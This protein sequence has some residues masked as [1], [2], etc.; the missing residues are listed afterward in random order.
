MRRRTCGA[1]LAAALFCC[2]GIAR[3]EGVV[4]DF[5]RGVKGFGD[6]MKGLRPEKT[7]KA[8]SDISKIVNAGDK[9]WRIIERNERIPGSDLRFAAAVPEGVSGWEELSRWG[10]PELCRYR[11]EVKDWLGRRAVDVEYGVLRTPGGSL[12]GQGRFLTGVSIVPLHVETRKDHKLS[13]EVEVLSVG[14]AGTPEDPLAAMTIL[15][16]WTVEAPGRV[17]KGSRA[18]HVRGDGVCSPIS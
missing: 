10:Q 2:A 13:M 8:V 12:R 18:F 11:F 7:A 15:L 1:A 9:A 3:A 4:V 16:R 17:E 5:D 14:N 6:W